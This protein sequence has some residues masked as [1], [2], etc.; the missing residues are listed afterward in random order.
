MTRTESTIAHILAAAEKLFVARTYADVSMR[1]IAEAAEVSTGALYHH[2]PGKEQLYYAMLT[3]YM[4]RTRQATLAARPLDST[5]RERLRALTRVY[6]TMRPAQRQIMRLVRRDLNAF[7]GKLRHGVVKAYQQA[8]PDLVEQVLCDAMNKKEI[9][10]QD[11]RWLAWAY[12]AIVETTLGEYAQTRLG[13]V[14]ARLDAALDLFLD[15]AR[16]P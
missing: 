3:T 13:T 4:A 9:R 7:N 2:F 1:D 12:V 6:L 14:D 8:V 11:P 10:T 16:R 15:G 5:C